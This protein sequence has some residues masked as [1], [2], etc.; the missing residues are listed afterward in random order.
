[1]TSLTFILYKYG[2][3]TPIY[4]LSTSTDFGSETYI[5]GTPA[6]G[7]VPVTPNGE[8]EY[9]ID[10]LVDSD[11]NGQSVISHGVDFGAITFEEGTHS[12]VISV[13]E[14]TTELANGIAD[15]PTETTNDPRPGNLG[16]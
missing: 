14:G 8:G 2:S 11:P 1:M 9:H 12:I 4:Y 6:T 13:K 16:N 15:T 10:L 3:G 7:T 5:V